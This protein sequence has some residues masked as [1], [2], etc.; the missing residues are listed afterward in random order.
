MLKID[1]RTLLRAVS[2]AWVAALA[3][4]TARAKDVGWLAEIQTP[5]QNLPADKPKLSDL[6]VNEAGQRIQSRESWQ[7]RREELRRWWLEFLGPMPA[8]RDPA[9]PPKLE[10]V[11]EDRQEGVV[12]QLVR[13]EVEPGLA[14]EAYLLKPAKIEGKVPGIVALH[15]TVDYSIRQ[16]AGL[17][18]PPEKCSG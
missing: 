7:P 13:Y 2:A 15:S 4:R 9:R 3:P 14:T 6:L 1:R 11:A 18:G 12:R 16:P 17:E 10:I 8:E 5:P